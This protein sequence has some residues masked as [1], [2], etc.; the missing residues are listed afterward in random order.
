VDDAGV[1]KNRSIGARMH[2]LDDLAI[3]IEKHSLA[4]PLVMPLQH[5]V[6]EQGV[7]ALALVV[8][9]R[10]TALPEGVAIGILPHHT[11]PM[12]HALLASSLVQLPKFVCG[13]EPR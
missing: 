6:I 11:Q 8:H 5:G 2:S 13:S 10:A 1:K 7:A 3:C 9:M 12:P 4:I